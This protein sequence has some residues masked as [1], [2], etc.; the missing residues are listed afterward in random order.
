MLTWDDCAIAQLQ[1]HW[2]HRHVLGLEAHA[3][4]RAKDEVTVTAG[5][6]EP[7]AGQAGRV[8]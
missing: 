7:F 8:S 3:F 5:P 2:S 4:H 1:Q 6:G